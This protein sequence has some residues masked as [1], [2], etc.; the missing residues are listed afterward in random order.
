MP[1]TR[2]K[3]YNLHMKTYTSFNFDSYRLD[4]DSR[5]IYL[6]YSFTDG[7]TFTEHIVLPSTLPLEEANNPALDQA[8]FALHLAGGVSYYKAFCPPRIN[9]HSGRLSREQAD[10][11]NYFY[12]HGLG[13]FFFQN[14]IDFRGL[15]QF[16][17]AAATATAL[18]PTALPDR[19]RRAL[20]PFGGGKDSVV[21]M[22]LLR[23]QNVEQTL[24]RVNAHHFIDRLADKTSLPLLQVSRRID[25]TILT[26]NAEGAYNGHVP[27]TG[28]I[29]FLT[30]VVAML[31]GYDSVW[32]SNE[33]S[34]DYG[35]VRYLDMDVN[36]QWS[37]SLDAEQHQRTYITRFI[38]GNVL[39][40]SLLRPLSELKIASLFAKYP[41]YF[42]TTT[43]CNVNWKLLNTNPKDTAW[44]GACYKCA[45][46]F[47]LYAAMLPAD[48]VIH[49][50]GKNMFNDAQLLSTFRQLWG[51]EGIKPFDCVGTPQEMQ[52]AM[53]LASKKPAFAP[54]LAVQDFTTHVLPA[55]KDPEALVA[56]A[57]KDDVTGVPNYILAMLNEALS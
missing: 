4:V 10:F 23:S 8:L 55:I 28:Y 1:P 21:T 7:P 40:G 22:E 34:A 31:G 52:A 19:P 5:T 49:M 3:W 47:A 43:S 35:N 32:F 27:I 39:F 44:C 6:N 13:E 17:A 57:L 29:G 42:D 56:A 12:T 15:V 14:K 11:W 18:P 25:R 30:V 36:H 46:I 53:Y 2:F 33:R 37:K 50:Y 16:P 38:T 54:T 9:V 41:H 45:F 24:F 51:A 20:T 48:S 26:L